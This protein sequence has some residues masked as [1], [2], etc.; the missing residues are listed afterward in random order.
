MAAEKQAHEAKETVIAALG[1]RNFRGYALGAGRA[2]W[3]ILVRAT[4]SAV[5]IVGG[6]FRIAH[7]EGQQRLEI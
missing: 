4:L 5:D 3:R 1:G 7:V 2:R 6:R